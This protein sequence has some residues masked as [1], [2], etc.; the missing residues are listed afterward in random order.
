MQTQSPAPL[1]SRQVEAVRQFLKNIQCSKEHG[2][3]WLSE[4]EVLKVVHAFENDEIVASTHII[5]ARQLSG[6]PND[7]LTH[8]WVRSFAQKGC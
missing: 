1:T 5:L 2:D 8:A 6:G 7:P 4:D 3:E